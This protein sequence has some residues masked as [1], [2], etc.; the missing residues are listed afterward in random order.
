MHTVPINTKLKIVSLV[1]WMDITFEC[2]LIETASYL[3]DESMTVMSIANI[4]MRMMK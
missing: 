3:Y 4:I 1:L 2:D